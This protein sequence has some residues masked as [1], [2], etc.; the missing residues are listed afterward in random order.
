[1]LI[2]TKLVVFP[3][4]SIPKNSLLK[5]PSIKISVFP[6]L[7]SV[8]LN[9]LFLLIVHA[10]KNFGLTLFFLGASAILVAGFKLFNWTLFLANPRITLESISALISFGSA[11]AFFAGPLLINRFGIRFATACS[12]GACLVGLTLSGV[13]F[14]LY[15]ELSFFIVAGLIVGFG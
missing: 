11:F 4:R 6:D 3:I 12:F 1:M 14:P 10:Y 5:K 7:G 2:S 15:Q 9:N 13:F 8:P